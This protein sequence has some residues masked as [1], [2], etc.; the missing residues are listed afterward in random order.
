LAHDQTALAQTQGQLSAIA[1]QLRQQAVSS[2]VD[3]SP[4]TAPFHGAGGYE[5]LVQG[6]YLA[7]VTQ[8][9]RDAVHRLEGARSALQAEQAKLEADERIFQLAQGGPGGAQTAS[10]ASAILDPSATALAF[11]G[12]PDFA[13]ALLKT[14]GDPL[15]P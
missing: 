10:A 12:P 14:L 9:E 8:N 4:A 15:T 7:S 5:R 2:Y 1:A 3:G 6:E 11:N 13:V